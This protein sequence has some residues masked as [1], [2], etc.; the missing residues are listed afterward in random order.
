MNCHRMSLRTSRYAMIETVDG[1]N[2]RAIFFS[3]KSDRVSI[4]SGLIS[5]EIKQIKSRTRAITLPG[6][7]KGRMIEMKSPKQHKMNIKIICLNIF[8]KNTTYN[9]DFSINQN[10]CKGIILT[11]I[12]EG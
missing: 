3:K 6:K 11:N 4:C 12:S 10:F 9:D 5:F 8:K 1:M 7:G 2:M